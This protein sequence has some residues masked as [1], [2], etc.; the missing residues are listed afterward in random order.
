MTFP[1]KR[2]WLGSEIREGTAIVKFSTQSR[3]WK[4]RFRDTVIYSR[5]MALADNW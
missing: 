1:Q 2:L 5:R 3:F 4:T